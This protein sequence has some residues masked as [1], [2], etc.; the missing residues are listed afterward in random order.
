[1]WAMDDPEAS[2]WRTLS[3]RT[4][5][6]NPW[7]TVEE[8]AVIRPDGQPG[9]Y[10]VV[11]FPGR[12]IGIVALDEDDRTCLVGQYRYTIGRYSWEIPEGAAGPEEAPLDAARRE[13]AEETGLRA[14]SWEELGRAHLSNSVTDE[15]AV[16]FLATGLSDGAAAPE[17]TERL[18]VRRLPF[19]AALDLVAAG[20]ITDALTVLGLQAVALRRRARA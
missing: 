13:L 5:Y 20:E 17:P 2:P 1:M 14:A 10:G 4:V 19:D 9:I 11:R 6:S 7:I 15:E 8:D 12:A 18:Q 3:R 16:L